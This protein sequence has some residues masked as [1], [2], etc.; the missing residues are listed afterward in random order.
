MIDSQHLTTYLTSISSN[1]VFE[2]LVENLI[3]ARS[4][5][6]I[7][8][9]ATMVGNGISYYKSQ[10][11]M[12]RKNITSLL[13]QI[14]CFTQDSD[15]YRVDEALVNSVITCMVELLTDPDSDVRKTSARDLGMVMVCT[16][17]H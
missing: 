14:L 8:M 11:P 15:N 9:Y 12:M 4:D 6:L 1:I 3:N 13:S 5:I 2:K 16:S 7:D 17:K 10:N